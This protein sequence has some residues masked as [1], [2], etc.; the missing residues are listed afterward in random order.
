MF[1]ILAATTYHL[2]FTSAWLWLIALAF[3]ATVVLTYFYYRRTNPMLSRGFRIALGIL[4]GLALLALFFVFAEPL[5]VRESTNDKAPVVAI[6]TDNSTSMATNRHSAEQFK[7]IDDYLSSI[8]SRLPSDARVVQY[9][10]ADT[11]MPDKPAGT[12]YPVTAIGTALQQLARAYD[13]ENLQA[14]VLLSDG[15]SNLGPNPVTEAKRLEVPITTIGFG[16]P[17]PLPDIRI[18]KVDCNP[19]GFVGKEFPVE[20]VLESRGFE[21]LRLPLR[22]RQGQRILTQ[23]EFDLIGQGRQQTVSLK[24]APAAEGD[25]VIEASTPVQT[26]EES[27]KNNSKR[28]HV[29]IRASQI[30]ILLAAAYLNWDYKFLHRALVAK[31]DFKVDS[32][33]AANQKIG[34]TSAFPENIEGLNEYDALI[35]YDFDADWFANRKQLFDAF[36]DRTGKGIFILAAEKFGQ[37]PKTRLPEGL[38]PYRFSASPMGI[39]RQEVQMTLTERGRIHPLVRLAEDGAASQ[40]LLNALPPFSGYLLSAEPANAATVIAALPALSPDQPDLPIFAA[41]RYRSGKVACLSA[42]PFWRLDFLAKSFNDA[43]ST[44]SQLVENMV[45]WLVAREDVERITITPEK[46]IFIAGEAVNLSARVLDEAYVPIEDAEVEAVVKSSQSPADSLVV[47]FRYDR[48]GLYSADLHY[49]PSG[50]YTV[51]GKVER[52]GVKLASPK[53]SFIVEP[54]SLEDLS[55]IANFDLLKRISEV[56]GGQF[57]AAAD[58]AAIPPFQTLPVKTVVRRSEFVLF[59]NIWLLGLIIAALCVEW[60]FRKRYQLL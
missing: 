40:R 49:L 1:R 42:F 17:N 31:A 4:R 45:L 32:Y 18:V 44:Y 34:G 24:F 25:L 38:F 26:N 22:L 23:Q 36:F 30:K 55:Q 5:L 58:T 29:K 41:Q 10:F 43:D 9:S 15:A 11:L 7:A 8:E 51:T 27:E 33:I 47:S 28:V 6:L 21:G 56:S 53:A 59:D 20:V 35:L 52:Q 39:V 54:Y 19:V 57:Y 14:V 46:P 3:L 50:E 48:P 2:S 60:Y 16:D 13:D 37:T 12:G